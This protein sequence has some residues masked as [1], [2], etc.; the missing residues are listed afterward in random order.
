MA[1]QASEIRKISQKFR[2]PVGTARYP[3]LD[4][5]D[6]K[7]SKDGYGEYKLDLVLEGEDA[8]NFKQE[9]AEVERKF[10]EQA[11]QVVPKLKR[12][13]HSCIKPF[14]DDEGNEVPDKI[15]VRMK[16]KAGGQRQD[17]T[18]WRSKPQVVDALLKP[19]TERVGGGSR[20][21]VAG[22][23]KA[24]NNAATGGFGV[25][26]QMRAVQVLDL[27]VP[28]DFTSEFEEEEG[29]TSSGD[30]A[31]PMDAHDDA[32]DQTDAGQEDF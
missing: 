3:R 20:V 26:S 14:E 28:G 9:V 12:G 11:Q 30:A 7:F 8:V 29:F 23:F 25:S 13:P 21:K 5:P 18:E 19:V 32:G 15:I 2:T 4:T 17:G 22:V 24:Y 6:T 27:V 1:N 16:L 31:P 10:F